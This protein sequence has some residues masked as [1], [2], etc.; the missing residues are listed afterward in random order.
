MKSI[1][2]FIFSVSILLAVGC[3]SNETTT[4]DWMKDDQPVYVLDQTTSGPIKLDTFQCSRVSVRKGTFNG[5]LPKNKHTVHRDKDS[6]TYSGIVYVAHK[7]PAE[8]I[9]YHRYQYYFKAAG[10]YSDV[11]IKHDTITNE[12]V[13]GVAVQRF[14]TRENSWHLD[15]GYK[16][17][18]KNS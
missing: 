2:V 18:A 1:Y 17:V 3:S 4:T 6:V 12:Q 15:F 11:Y 9:S 16:T 13:N 8:K 7:D 10:G 5:Q 14:S